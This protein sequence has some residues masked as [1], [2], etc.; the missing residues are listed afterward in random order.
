M[1]AT[2]DYLIIGGGAAGCL[3]ARRLADATGAHILLI[4]AGR[5][6]ENDPARLRPVAPG[7][8]G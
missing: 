8:A 2:C 4:E 1:T 3:L 5:S 6:D 7:R